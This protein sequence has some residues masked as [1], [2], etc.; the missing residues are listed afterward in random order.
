MNSSRAYL[1][2][3]SLSLMTTAIV[4]AGTANSN[5]QGVAPYRSNTIHQSAG[6]RD[7]RGLPKYYQSR[8]VSGAYASIRSPGFDF[9]SPQRDFQLEGR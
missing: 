9:V 6:E 1:V 5:A 8:R 2:V 3:A 7:S 4:L